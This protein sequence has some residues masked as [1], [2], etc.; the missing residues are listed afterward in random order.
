MI[1]APS[2]GVWPKPGNAKAPKRLLIGLHD[3]SQK[4]F[5]VDTLQQALDQGMEA[6]E[7]LDVSFFYNYN[8]MFKNAFSRKGS[9]RSR[10]T[11]Q[12]T[13]KAAS[14]TLKN[15]PSRNANIDLSQ[16]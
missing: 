4:Q 2:N 16:M 12:K 6:S 10:P 15:T 13:T 7:D 3:A 8:D 5:F 1:D 9:V 14:T 11:S